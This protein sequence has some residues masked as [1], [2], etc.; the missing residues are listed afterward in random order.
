[1]SSELQE[2]FFG[3]EEMSLLAGLKYNLIY[4]DI[5]VTEKKEK[6]SSKE[7]WL[8][9]WLLHAN[10]GLQ[11]IAGNSSFTTVE[12]TVENINSA[13]QLFV[14]N[15]LVFSQ[16]RMMLLELVLFEP[17]G[18]LEEGEAEEKKWKHIKKE[19]DEWEQLLGIQATRLNLPEELPEKYR[20]VLKSA[21][22][23]LTN[24]WKKM[25]LWSLGGAAA[26]AITGG[27]AATAIA[28][29]FAAAG[30]GGAAAVSSGLAAL[31]G[32]AIAAGGLG[33][34]GGVAV[35]VGGG[36]ILGGAVGASGYT[37]FA[38]SPKAALYES[39]KMEVVVR[40]IVLQDQQDVGKAL[41]LIKAQRETIRSLEDHKDELKMNKDEN[42][43]QI[44]N[45]EKSIYYL[46]KAVD[47]SMNYLSD[48]NR[49][50]KR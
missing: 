39:A 9:S 49:K 17:Y 30:L 45:L 7:Q 35:L 13:L 15:E 4:Q 20:K 37:M 41:E 42:K 22:N 33:M 11:S 32:G 40:E 3:L 21:M 10:K 36:A 14:S 47:R 29:M 27:F 44:K 48:F 19:K 26:I 5:L 24:K 6:R 34:A 1:M 25:G 23:G 18:P 50:S 28:P 12:D 2:F 46:K 31:G 8:V 16:S 43:K 38:S